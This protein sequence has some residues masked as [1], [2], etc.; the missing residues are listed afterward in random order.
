MN[1]C[2]YLSRQ[3]EVVVIS[4]KRS[5]F[6]CDVSKVTSDATRQIFTMDVHRKLKVST[7]LT[8]VIIICQNSKM[9]AEICRVA[10]VDE[11]AV[12]NGYCTN[13]PG[14]YTPT[15][16]KGYFGGAGDFPTLDISP[17][18]FPPN[19]PQATDSA[20]LAK[21]RGANILQYLTSVCS[22]TYFPRTGIRYK[23][24]ILR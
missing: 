6:R 22:F 5:R 4:E 12:N 16:I 20:A 21:S 19:P 7:K 9:C 3:L 2:K 17:R 24:F 1:I 14:N 11:C 15:C 18:T 13:T 23:F 8:D 10:D